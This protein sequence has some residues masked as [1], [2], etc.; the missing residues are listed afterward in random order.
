MALLTTT[1]IKS[2]TPGSAVLCHESLWTCYFHFLSNLEKVRL[3]VPT[4][5]PHVIVWHADELESCADIH[6]VFAE[7]CH[8]FQPQIIAWEWACHR[9]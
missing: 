2:G 8:L 4:R 9:K 6:E 3:T 5:V 7:T 1:I